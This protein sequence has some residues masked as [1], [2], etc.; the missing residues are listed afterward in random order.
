ML[1]WVGVFFDSKKLE[2]P[3]NSMTSFTPSTP[4]Y[5]VQF[6]DEDGHDEEWL[7]HIEITQRTNSIDPFTTHPQ[8]D[9]NES[10]I[11]T[12]SK[13]NKPVV[14]NYGCAFY[15]SG[16]NILRF[17][18]LIVNLFFIFL[19][20]LYGYGQIVTLQLDD[21]FCES[22]TLQQIREHSIESNLNEGTEDGCWTTSNNKIDESKLYNAGSSIAYKSVFNFT[23]A[24]IVKCALFMIIA[25]ALAIICIIFLV[26]II[27]DCK[28]FCNGSWFVIYLFA[29][30]LQSITN[31]VT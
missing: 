4:S 9:G 11:T 19:C 25:L 22:K 29:S 18:I 27:K 12:T 7:R 30:R 23:A 17:G 15:R 8:T 6:D 14:Y 28:R 10:P 21:Y 26:E 24:N 13:E 31:N 3:K 20:V 16:Y 2:T 5:T 1:R